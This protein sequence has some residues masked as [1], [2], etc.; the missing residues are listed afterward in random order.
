MNEEH[1]ADLERDTRF[2]SDAWT[3][4]FLQ[5]WFPGRQKM[6]MELRWSGGEVT[7]HGTDRVGP[8]TIN[9]TYDIAT[10]RC[11]WTKK[12][13]GRHS[14]A[15]RGVNDGHGIWGVWEIRQLGGLYVDRGGFHI[16]PEGSN[17]SE[18][19]DRT[20]KAV[21]EAMQVEF[22]T[23]PITPATLVAL[24]VLGGSVLA[25]LLWLKFAS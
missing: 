20:E 9:G 4:F 22:G 16:W 6:D 5:F 13:L 14:V 12:Y 8:F 17:V 23:L 18:E 19:S 25:I 15:Y 21:M 7:G 3:G 1:S 11:E 24:L 2:P 10:G